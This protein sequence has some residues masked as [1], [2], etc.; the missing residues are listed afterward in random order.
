MHKKRKEKCTAPCIRKTL[1]ETTFSADSRYLN[2][3]L[4]F[5]F[6]FLFCTRENGV[7]LRVDARGSLD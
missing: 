5:S 2:I 4:C 3:F 7:S 6:L 1:K